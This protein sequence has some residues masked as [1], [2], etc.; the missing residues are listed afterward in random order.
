M[1]ETTKSGRIYEALAKVMGEVGVV[2]KSRKNTQQNYAFRGIDD[3]VSA[4]QDVL[5]KHGVVVAPRVI[6]HQREVLATK[7]GGSM[8]SVRLLVEHT[9]F[10]ADGSS[11]VATT[12]G[13]AMDAGDKASN[14]AMSAALK[15]ALVETLMIPTYET[16]RDSETAS[17]EMAPRAPA[18]APLPAQRTATTRPASTAKAADQRPRPGHLTSASIAPPPPAGVTFPNYGRAK[19]LPV[20]GASMQD[21]EFY[22]NGA[23][24]SLADP[25]KERYH[26]SEKRLLDAI[27]GEIMRQQDGAPLD[28]ADQHGE[29]PPHTDEDVPF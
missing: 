12:L 9:F 27:E 14:K 16:D 2:G 19:G 6:E 15:Y 20:S 7:S 17:P 23:R 1:S 29:P 5:V 22:A 4:C 8:A 10:A 26:A 24:R 11:V 18:A 25:A 28:A 21:L 13:E 3:V